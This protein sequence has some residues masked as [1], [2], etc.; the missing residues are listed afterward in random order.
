MITKKHDYE[1]PKYKVV[2]FDDSLITRVQSGCIPRTTT[3]TFNG[4]TCEA[5]NDK[6]TEWTNR[7]NLP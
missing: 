5:E 3:F 6:I 2:R 1:A 4:Q 7:F